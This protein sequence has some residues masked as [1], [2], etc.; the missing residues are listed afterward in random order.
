M[1]LQ[2]K[3]LHIVGDDDGD[4]EEENVAMAHDR[5]A[6]RAPR[7]RKVSESDEDDDDEVSYNSDETSDDE[8][9]TTDD[10]WS[11]DVNHIT[12]NPHLSGTEIVMGKQLISPV[13]PDGLPVMGV[14]CDIAVQGQQPAVPLVDEAFPKTENQ[15][16]EDIKPVNS[17]DVKAPTE[18]ITDISAESVVA[19]NQEQQRESENLVADGVLIPGNPPV[20]I[21]PKAQTRRKTM[22]VP[23]R[24]QPV[25]I[26]A[27]NPV[28]KQSPS[29][30]T[31]IGGR[32]AKRARRSGVQ[33]I[34]P[35]SKVSAH[36]LAKPLEVSQYFSNVAATLV[37]QRV[38]L[39]PFLH[40]RDRID[41]LVN[42]AMLKTNLQRRL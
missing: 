1:P 11:M 9:S 36:T 41:V 39:L 16:Q 2:S 37:K 40:M 30:P 7:S 28:D 12:G 20:E 5:K 24:N 3:I 25:A 10:D 17:V 29:S 21:A 15:M 42:E 38:C 26:P 8:E 34:T 4:I 23:A 22:R 27:F 14:S 35:I 13:A 31:T 33:K 19:P 6:W 18:Q 32:V